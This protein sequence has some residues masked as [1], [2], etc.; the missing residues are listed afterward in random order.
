MPFRMTLWSQ[1]NLKRKNR[2]RHLL[3]GKDPSGGHSVNLKGNA[4]SQLIS[5]QRVTIIGL[6]IGLQQKAILFIF[7]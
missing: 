5:K 4:Y 6:F 1:R 3:Q 2:S 7:K